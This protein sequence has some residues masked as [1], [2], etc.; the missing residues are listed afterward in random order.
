MGL[1]RH[2]PLAERFCESL[3]TQGPSLLAYS[4]VKIL[5]L[6]NSQ[7]KKWRSP[8]SAP[9]FFLHRRPAFWLLESPV[10]FSG[11]CRCDHFPPSYPA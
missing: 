5:I 4:V 3:P 8:T 7:R 6:F 11:V 2:C 10:V 9:K 1:L